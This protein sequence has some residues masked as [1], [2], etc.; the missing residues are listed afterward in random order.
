MPS[1]VKEFLEQAIQADTS[2]LKRTIYRHQSR[3]SETLSLLPSY[4]SLLLTSLLLLIIVVLALLFF[5]RSFF[6]LF[7]LLFLFTDV[8]QLQIFKWNP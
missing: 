3:D 6:L 4:F 5:L 7:L 8:S 1:I 2:L